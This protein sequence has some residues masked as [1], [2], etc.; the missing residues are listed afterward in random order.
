MSETQWLHKYFI[1]FSIKKK[2]KEKDMKHFKLWVA[3]D[4]KVWSTSTCLQY[5]MYYLGLL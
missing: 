2:E 1:P 3:A 4:D 5:Y